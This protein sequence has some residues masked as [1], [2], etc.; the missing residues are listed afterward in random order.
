MVIPYFLTYS[1]NKQ[2]SAYEYEVFQIFLC[3]PFLN[4]PPLKL[5]CGFLLNLFRALSIFSPSFTGITNIKSF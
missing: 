1:Q 2:L 3:I 4:E 5:I